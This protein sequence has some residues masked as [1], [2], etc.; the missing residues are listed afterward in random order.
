MLKL[1]TAS[2]RMYAYVGVVLVMGFLLFQWQTA[3]KDLTVIRAET[4]A[5]ITSNI[6]EINDLS[7][8]NIGNAAVIDVIKKDVVAVEQS[9]VRIATV[10]KRVEKARETAHAAIEKNTEVIYIS[11]KSVDILA[12]FIA[13]V[14][15][16][17]Y[18]E[19]S[20]DAPNTINRTENKEV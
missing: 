3:Q 11:E 4:G 1:F 9:Q 10:T 17:L 18:P 8:I 6:S 19:T 5:V 15:P 13:E 12:A 7:K 14:E 2:W 16:I 20:E